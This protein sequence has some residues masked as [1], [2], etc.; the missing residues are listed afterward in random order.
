MVY[1]QEISSVAELFRYFLAVSAG[2][3]T[4]FGSPYSTLHG[5][6]YFRVCEC[7]NTLEKVASFEMDVTLVQLRNGFE[8][9]LLGI[10]CHQINPVIAGYSHIE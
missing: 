8:R 5:S 10:K 7:N 4:Y 1:K 9:C 3:A 2:L 6:V